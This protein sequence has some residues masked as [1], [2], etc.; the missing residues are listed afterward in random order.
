MT[1]AIRG[2]EGVGQNDSTK[3]GVEGVGQEE[4]LL[5]RLI[6]RIVADILCNNL[7]LCWKKKIIWKF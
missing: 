7:L 3:Q 6:S 2:V 4:L 5:K 1:P